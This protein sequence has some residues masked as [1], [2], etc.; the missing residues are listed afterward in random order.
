[1]ATNKPYSGYFNV[2]VG[3]ELH[4]SA[5]RAARD[6]RI[7][8]NELVVRALQASVDQAASLDCA[9][10]AGCVMKTGYAVHDSIP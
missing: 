9:A 8:L 3:Q 6:S 2:L 5:A 7:T 4:R 1:M 10:G